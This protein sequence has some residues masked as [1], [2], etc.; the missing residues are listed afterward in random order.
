MVDDDDAAS[1]LYH[2]AV[3]DALAAVVYAVQSAEHRDGVMSTVHAAQRF[4]DLADLV[5]QQGYSDYR[6]DARYEAAMAYATKIILDDIT[7]VPRLRD[8][9]GV[10][11]Y[12]KMCDVQAGQIL[13]LGINSG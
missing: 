5:L 9:A 13:A 7:S 11:A 4:L 2:W 3:N 8:D 6:S 12:R 1:G 10:V